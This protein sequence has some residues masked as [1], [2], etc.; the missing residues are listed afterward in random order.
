MANSTLRFFSSLH[1]GVVVDFS[2]NTRNSFWKKVE[3]VV[4]EKS[5]I[6]NIFQGLECPFFNDLVE[7]LSFSQ[8]QG[9]N[10]QKKKE[11]FQQFK[12]ECKLEIRVAARFNFILIDF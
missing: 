6:L 12:F 9:V 2:D 7:F 5:I 3:I 1:S 11:S 8:L 10:F 4:L